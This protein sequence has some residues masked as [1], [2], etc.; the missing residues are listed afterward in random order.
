MSTLTFQVTG[1]PKGQ[2]RPRA[3][4]RKMGSIHV[5]RFYDSDVADV[6][7]SAV[8]IALLEMATQTR[9]ELTL[10]PVSVSLNFAM[11]RP[12]S[13]SG[14]KGLRPSAPVQ[15][16]GKP[17]V[18]NLAKLILDQITRSGCV[19]RDDSQV[20]SLHV[21]KFWAAGADQGCSVWI[22]TLGI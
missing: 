15:H 10:G 16:I 12:K 8:Q 1:D 18:D 6:W 7:K 20:V 4:A 19:W 14:A 21:H 11:P 2:P 22:S 17:D 13:H 5:A 9:W 3:F